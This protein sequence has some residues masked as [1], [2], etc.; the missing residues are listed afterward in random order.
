MERRI[1]NPSLFLS[2]ERFF[3]TR[4]ILTAGVSLSMA[5]TGLLLASPS[6]ATM[7]TSARAGTTATHYAMQASGY[8][9]R[10]I[11][12]NLPAGSDRTAFQVIGCTNKAGLSKQNPQANLNLNN[13]L[14]G[15]H[16]NAATTHV[17]TTKKNNTVS[18]VANNHIA[19]VTIAG[20]ATN[21]DDVVLTG[22]NSRSRTWHDGSGYHA[23]TKATVA[24]ITVGGVT[25]P[26]P[27][28]GTT[29]N[30]GILGLSL[31][32]GQRSH[33]GSGATAMLDAVKLTVPLSTT[34]VYL[35]HSRSTIN[36]GVVSGLFRGSAYA[37]KAQAL[38]GTA[39]VGKTPLI[40]M[41][42]QGTNG[43]V[44]RRDIARVNPSGLLLKGLHAD[45]SADQT[46]S[47]ASGYERGSVAR[48][49]LGN[50][51]KTLVVRGIVGKASV[52]Y[53]RGNGLKTSVKG[54]HLLGVTVNGGARTIGPDNVLTIKGLATLRT[55]IVKRTK[56]SIRITEL[57]I[58]VL[59][60]ANGGAQID[61]G[62]AKMGFNRSGL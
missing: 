7:E 16:I 52:H 48:V 25:K 18:S 5:A 31:G 34:R 8:S 26:V 33:N 56:S 28:P 35:A 11:G 62:V 22:V 32:N 50:A 49:Q 6:Q 17:W 36:G 51:G 21:L 24:G 43:K 54:S 59:G 53:M 46:R 20:G 12:G 4:A 29:I 44:I 14:G 2:T 58:S 57:R 47:M 39:K 60:G 38:A 41:P 30:L 1:Y 55:H 27:S 15:I 23:S 9:S 10:V 42:C 37:A 13:I 40:V 19:S 45:Q 3:M 61:L